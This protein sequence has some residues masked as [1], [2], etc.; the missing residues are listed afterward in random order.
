MAKKRPSLLNAFNA[1]IPKRVEPHV[2]APP[3]VTPPEPQRSA[4]PRF[5]ARDDQTLPVRA[6]SPVPMAPRRAVAPLQSYAP[7]APISRGRMLLLAIVGASIL[8]AVV[9]WIKFGKS[10]DAHEALAHAGAPAATGNA[11]NSSV[12]PATKNS[13]NGLDPVAGQTDDD[14]AFL[15]VRNKF[16]VRIVQYDNDA[17]GIKLARETYKYLRG[18]RI[19]AVQPI[20]SGDGRH[21]FLCADAKPKREDLAVLVGYI[22]HMRG[23]DQKSIPFGD[24]YVEN[25]ERL[26]NR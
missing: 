16:T 5:E 7:R 18:D 17:T 14:K 19:P 10:G 21:I 9:V 24:A 15:D 13:S 26:I 6:S 8:L 12:S 1:A 20:Q 11:A 3:R 2:A 4:Q 22:K 23:P 25:I